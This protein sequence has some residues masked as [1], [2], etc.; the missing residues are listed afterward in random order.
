MVTQPPTPPSP[1]QRQRG[2]PHC[3]AAETP[4]I[5]PPFPLTI[6]VPQASPLKKVLPVR[7]STSSPCEQPTLFLEASPSNEGTGQDLWLPDTRL[8]A[9]RTRREL[10]DNPDS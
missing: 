3:W 5:T 6:R 4:L 9:P 10:F 7:R 2:D 8:P 1:Q